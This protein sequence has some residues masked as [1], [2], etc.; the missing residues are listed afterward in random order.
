MLL[1]LP[2][3]EAEDA[4]RIAIALIWHQTGLDFAD[5]LHLAS[6]QHCDELYT[7]DSDFAKQGK[8]VSSCVVKKL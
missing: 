6:S 3:V 5:A 7:F 1:G 4:G 8:E 2:N